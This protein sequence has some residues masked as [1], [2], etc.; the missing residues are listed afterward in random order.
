MKS[1][2]V[3][4][5][6]RVLDNGGVI[7]YPT[8]AVMGLGCNPWNEAAVAKVLRLKRRSP[9]KGLIIVAAGSRTVI[10]R[11][12]FFPGIGDGTGN[13]FVAGA[14]HL[15]GAGMAGYASLAHRQA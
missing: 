7:A 3:K 2:H 1:W 4:N 5:A 13:R 11:G 10:R 9:D 15:A 12:G 8:E 14:G 6:R